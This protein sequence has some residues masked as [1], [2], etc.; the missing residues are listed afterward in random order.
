[1]Q[2]RQDKLKAIGTNGDAQ[3]FLGGVLGR[4]VTHNSK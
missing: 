4:Y 3:N 1:M 2:E